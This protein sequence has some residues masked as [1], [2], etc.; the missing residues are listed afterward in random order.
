MANSVPE[1]ARVIKRALSG[2]LYVVLVIILVGG[3]SFGL[4]RLSMIESTRAPVEIQYEEGQLVSQGANVAKSTSRKE[5]L[6]PSASGQYVASRNSTK[7]HFPWCAGAQRIKEENKIW[8]DSK[9]EAT[10]AGYSPAANCDG[11]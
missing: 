10:R 6:L 8:F 3:A 11:L 5:A 2:D 1:S 9:E 4:G 7:Y